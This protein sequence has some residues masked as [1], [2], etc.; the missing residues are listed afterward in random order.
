MQ[1][2]FSHSTNQYLLATQS[3][4]VLFQ[5]S[6]ILAILEECPVLKSKSANQLVNVSFIGKQRMKTLNN[7][8]RDKSQSTDV[9]SFELYDQ[10]VM[11]ELYICPDDIA[12][13]A[14]MLGHAIEHE[15][16]E[17]IIHGL[18]HLSGYDHSDEMF[19]WQKKLTERILEQY[20]N[21]RR[22]R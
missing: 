9:L 11:G 14:K 2:E 19:D 1:I 7:T 10:G 16:I 20:E 21:S 8:Y 13:N 18:L 17:I 3:I 12:K 5:H 15:L 4:S 22:S 6:M